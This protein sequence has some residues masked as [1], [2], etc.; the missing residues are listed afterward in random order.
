MAIPRMIRYTPMKTK[1]HSLF[2]RFRS[3]TLVVIAAITPL[4]GQGQIATATPADFAPL[5]S[6][7]F[8]STPIL[9]S[10]MH[11]GR[12]LN[13]VTVSSVKNSSHPVSTTS[14]GHR[15]VPRF[16]PDAFLT[17][18]GLIAVELPWAAN[19]PDIF[20]SLLFGAPKAQAA[21]WLHAQ[22]MQARKVRRIHDMID[23]VALTDPGRAKFYHTLWH[24]GLPASR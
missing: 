6:H 16:A 12:P 18:K 2:R 24:R 3:P 15:S 22:K 20:F 4:S 21:A 8:T 11:F 14:F 10:P 5:A 7:V 19:M 1:T 13:H 9:N 17:G 23:M